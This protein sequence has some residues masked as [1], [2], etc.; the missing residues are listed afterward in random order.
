MTR[1][2]WLHT[3]HLEVALWVRG[4]LL[5]IFGD[6]VG[7]DTDIAFASVRQ[8]LHALAVD[9]LAQVLLALNAGKAAQ[10]LSVDKDVPASGREIRQT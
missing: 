5:V 6:A 3:E 10:R 7:A 4:V 1:A 8:T 9:L 2:S